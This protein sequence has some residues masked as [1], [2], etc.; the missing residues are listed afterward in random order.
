MSTLWTPEGEH[1][2]G[3]PPPTS[4]ETAPPAP[5]GE[6]AAAAEAEALREE[7]LAAS[8]ED[9]VANH[10]FGLFQ[11]A[12]LHLDAK[13]PSLDKARLAIDALGGIVDT[14]GDRLGQHAETL[15]GALASIRL[16]FVELSKAGDGDGAGASG[17]GSAAAP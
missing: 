10:C 12:A 15:R 7:L 11:L 13:P 16:A 4:G 1:R 8:V 17:D 3:A 14:V 9:I 2:V 5:S 6:P